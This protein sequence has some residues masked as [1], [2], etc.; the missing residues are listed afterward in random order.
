MLRE[1]IKSFARKLLF[2]RA[3]EWLLRG[4]T[5]STIESVQERVNMIK[6]F[7]A[8]YSAAIFVESGT[9]LGDTVWL[10]KDH[11]Q[12][13]YT[14]ELEPSL[15]AFAARRFK[16]YP[17]IQVLSGDSATVLPELLPKIQEKCLFFLDAH[18]GGGLSGGGPHSPPILGELLAIKNHHIK[19]HIIVI[20]D[21]RFFDGTK[22]YPT[23]EEL[24][25][26]F[27]SVN[28]HY[29]LEERGDIIVAV[30]P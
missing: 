20:D 4:V 23:K 12:K 26:L 13:I 19:N 1:F 30:A 10:L 24:K 21:A 11:F 6:Q 17:H 29:Q 7:A 9:Y 3:G 14:I 22:G 16:K 2:F 15:A 27:L 8:E 28:P 25:K 5:H 18:Y